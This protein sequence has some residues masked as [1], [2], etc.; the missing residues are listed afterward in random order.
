V[1]KETPRPTPPL[2]QRF[3]D[4]CHRR[5]RGG[6]LGL[7]GMPMGMADIAEVARNAIR[8]AALMR[9]RQV[10]VLTHDSIGLGEDGP[11]HQP[12]EH[13]AS[14][15]LISRPRRL[16]PGRQLR[17]RGGLGL[18]GRTA[19]RVERAPPVARICRLCPGRRRRSPTFAAAIPKPNT[20]PSCLAINCPTCRPDVRRTSRWPSFRSG[21]YSIT[22]RRRASCAGNASKRSAAPAWRRRSSLFRSSGWRRAIA[23]GRVLHSLAGSGRAGGA[24]N[25][26]S[27]LILSGLGYYRRIG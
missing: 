3:A 11:T 27:G 14:L 12:I 18:R 6:Q 16:A 22:R 23:S 19:R 5:R 4:S 1:S 20:T 9:L 7:P 26:P 25:G 24:S 15:R 10:M 17:D 21:S 13:A 2:R 8:I